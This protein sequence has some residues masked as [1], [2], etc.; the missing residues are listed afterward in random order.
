MS[1]NVEQVE[2]HTIISRLSV[3]I[4]N[5][6]ID[7]LDILLDHLEPG[8]DGVRRPI[9]PSQVTVEKRARQIR[10]MIIARIFIL[11]R[12]LDKDTLLH[13]L[14]EFKSSA[15]QWVREFPRIA[16]Y[17]T[18]DFASEGKAY[19]SY[20][21]DISAGGIFIETLERFEIGQEISL[22]FSLTEMNERLPFK[23]KGAV[24]RICREG[25][26]VQYKNMTLYQRGIL[27]TL[28]NKN[29]KK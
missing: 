6:D 23:I 21:R 12:Q 9:M 8:P 2:K 4:Y 15:F 20:I 28:L 29:V 10:S 17:L 11:I 1:D 3:S 18:V 5:M 16:C 22:C 24:T 19:Q 14:R 13:R 7:E 25:I 27:N 26:G